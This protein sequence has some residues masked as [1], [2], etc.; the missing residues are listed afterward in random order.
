MKKWNKWLWGLA[1]VPVLCVPLIAQETKTPTP[2][3]APAAAVSDGEKPE[4]AA[5]QPAEAE[6]ERL[7]AD[8]T[9][10]FPVDI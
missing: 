3:P 2:A 8:N 9:L 4:P 1:A 5:Q 10:S 6:G 7:S